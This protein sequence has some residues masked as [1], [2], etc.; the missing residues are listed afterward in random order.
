MRYPG[1]AHG[2]GLLHAHAGD[3]NQLG[4]LGALESRCFGASSTWDLRQASDL[5]WAII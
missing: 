1:G 2:S 3:V 4:E 5:S